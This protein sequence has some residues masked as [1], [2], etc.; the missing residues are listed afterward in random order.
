MESSLAYSNLSVH[1]PAKYRG[2]HLT[3]VLSKVAERVIGILMTHFFENTGAYSA[4]Q[5]AFQRGRSH[6][7][8]IALLINSW[9]LAL[10]QGKKIGLYLSDISGAFDRVWTPLLMKKL[11]RSGLNA[12]LLKFLE[13]YLTEHSRKIAVNGDFSDAFELSNMVY[14]GTVLGPVLWNVFFSDISSVMAKIHGT[15]AKF[16]DDLNVYKLYCAKTSNDDIMQELYDC[17][18]LTH[19]WGVEHRVA[20][21]RTKEEFTI[22]HR[23]QG[24]GEPFRLLGPVIDHALIMS[25]AID[26]LVGKCRPKIKAILRTTRHYSVQDMV[27]QFKTHVLP[28]AELATPAVY[29]A[30]TSVLKTS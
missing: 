29:H 30:S 24:Q 10:E 20:F 4:S 17:Q 13:N 18:K 3:S 5:W 2:V 19:E 27:L 14:Q 11:W 12:E 1:D 26:K 28:T 8:L 25:E 21:D 7:D 16:A 22:I 6:S 9:I 15:E 23:K